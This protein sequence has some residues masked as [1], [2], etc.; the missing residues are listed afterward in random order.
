MG[1]R[2]KETEGASEVSAVL[3]ASQPSLRWSFLNPHSILEPRSQAPHNSH[4]LNRPFFPQTRA[5]SG[6]SQSTGQGSLH[7]L[8]S[9]LPIPTIHLASIV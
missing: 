5:T 4:S 3:F 8:A 1:D 2:E 6:P 9:W 7:S